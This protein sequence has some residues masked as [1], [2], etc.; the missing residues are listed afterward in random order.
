MGLC[1]APV[2][3]SDL[4]EPTQ[5][6][7]P[8][9]VLQAET[10]KESIACRH[11]LQ[12]DIEHFLPTYQERVPRSGHRPVLANRVL[13]GGYIFA[14]FPYRLKKTVVETPH[15]Y[16]LVTFDSVPARVDDSE[17]SSIRTMIESGEILRPIARLVPGS[18]IRIAFGP[19]AGVSGVLARMA[20][21]WR[22]VVN[23]EMLGRA[24]CVTVDREMVIPA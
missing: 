20:G 1:F 10:G 19:L 11:L 7:E 23:V 17:I 13:F 18:R 5:A 8:W 22:A 24:V 14:R 3:G 6:A 15:I 4:R 21:E 9:M 16:N 2:I 12:R